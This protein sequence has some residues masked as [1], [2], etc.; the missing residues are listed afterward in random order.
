MSPRMDST[1]A[2]QAPSIKH[3]HEEAALDDAVHLTGYYPSYETDSSVIPVSESG[4]Q[5]TPA[6]PS[7]SSRRNSGNT[8]SWAEPQCTVTFPSNQAREF[9]TSAVRRSS[10]ELLGIEMR[11]ETPT[12][13]PV[14]KGL[15]HGGAA[16]SADLRVGDVLLE[17]NG[18]P[19]RNAAV[20]SV[21]IGEAGTTVQFKVLRPA[22]PL[23]SVP[24]HLQHHRACWQPYDAN[25]GDEEPS[26]SCLRENSLCARRPERKPA[27][28]DDGRGG[29]F[30]GFLD[31][32]LGQFLCT[33]SRSH[34]R[35]EPADSWR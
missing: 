7:R 27:S 15:R 8:V 23:G 13:P 22:N 32:V 11:S 31:D 5:R 10:S 26:W 30:G 24:P 34:G 29:V 21:L 9:T 3:P 25:E 20:A 18:R 19:T 14:V 35:R 6:G 4:G 2:L 16:R 33:T 17:V 1:V 12:D 28:V